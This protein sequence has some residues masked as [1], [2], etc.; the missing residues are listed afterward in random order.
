VEVEMVLGQV[1]EDAAG[2]ADPGDA[3]ELERVRG[4]LHGR[5]AVAGV[6][7]SPEGGLEI[8]RLGR[9]PLDLLL[10]A[11]DDA[12]DGP[13]Q[14]RLAPGRLEQVPD[15]EGRGRLAVRARDADHV[16]LRGRVAI[17]TRR[18]GPHRGADVLY[19]QLG[20]AEVEPP[21]GHER[22]GPP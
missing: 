15:E 9:R 8:D 20:H 16:E 21:L 18:C 4:D 13:Q 5:R 11:A 12:L 22:R 7:H 3:A 10:Y 17:E 2:E 1:G 19:D 14:A 6:E